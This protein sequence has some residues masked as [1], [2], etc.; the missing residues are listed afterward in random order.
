LIFAVSKKSNF[1]L[2]IETREPFLKLLL[3]ELFTIIL[4]KMNKQ[5]PTPPPTVSMGDE[6]VVGIRNRTGQGEIQ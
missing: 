6:G 5:L 2:S 3:P 4:V 1:L